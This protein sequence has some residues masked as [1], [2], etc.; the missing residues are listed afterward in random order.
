MI[1]TLRPYADNFIPVIFVEDEILHTTEKPF[2]FVD[3]SCPCHED[4][5]LIAEVAAFVAHGL[6]TPEEAT[7]FVAGR[8]V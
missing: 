7:D 3:P 1:G 2:C 6:M 4:H 8:T 5:T